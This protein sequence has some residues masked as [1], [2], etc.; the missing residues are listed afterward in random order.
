MEQISPAEHS[1]CVIGL[2]EAVRKMT[3]LPAARTGLADRGVLREGAAADVAVFD[4]AAV[5]DRSTYDE[6]WRLS[7]GFSTVLVNGVPGLVDGEL[8]RTPGAGR[9]LTR[10]AA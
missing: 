8:T 9:V 3:S 5:T 6:P 4:P 1:G 2:E 7:T 10:R